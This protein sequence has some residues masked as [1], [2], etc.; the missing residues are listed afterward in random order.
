MDRILVTL[1][2]HIKKRGGSNLFKGLID[3]TLV[4]VAETLFAQLMDFRRLMVRYERKAKN[5]LGFVRL[6]CVIILR[7]HFRN[8]VL[9]APS[10][11][12]QQ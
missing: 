11:Q 6:G 9:R 2:K 1:A 7:G 8:G 10:P 12:Q 4:S 3:G 5:Y